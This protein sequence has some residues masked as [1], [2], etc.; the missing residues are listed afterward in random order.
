MKVAARSLNSGPPPFQELL[1]QNGA[2]V[3]AEVLET[4]E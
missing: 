1:D 3:K 4:T 2:T